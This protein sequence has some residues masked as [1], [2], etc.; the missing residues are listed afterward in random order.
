MTITTLGGNNKLLT[1]LLFS[2][3][4][5]RMHRWMDQRVLR[6]RRDARHA[7]ITDVTQ[8][9]A[10]RRTQTI[11][12]VKAPLE[13]AR[14]QVGAY[15]LIS[16]LGRGGMGEVYLG[17]HVETGAHAAVK[18]LRAGLSANAEFR[19]RFRR[20]AR[21][22]RTLCHPNILGIVDYGIDGD[23]FYMALEVIDGVTLADYLTEVKQMPLEQSLQV[24]EDVAAALDHAHAKGI[25]HRD[26]KPRNVML[27]QTADGGMAAVLMDFGIVKWLEGTASMVGTLTS[28]GM[29][30]TVDYAA[31]EQITAAHEVDSRA[32]IYALGMMA[33]LMMTGRLP[34]KGSVGQVVFAHLQQTPTDPHLINSALPERAADA[35]VRALAKA[36]E[37][38]FRAAGEFA[39]ALR[40]GMRMS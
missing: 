39:A 12:M 38:R 19:A 35:I 32:D 15:R 23:S 16:V 14:G 11:E 37:S 5:Q 28:G 25:V 34:F 4:F 30:G 9:D 22:L 13:E 18:V 26:V 24:I 6:L 7:T 33:Y 36:P 40:L 1:R 3:V 27:R 20:E 8:P 29:I 17:E 21:T 31:P 10:R 2:P